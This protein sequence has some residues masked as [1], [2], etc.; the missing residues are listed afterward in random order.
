MMS[1]YAQANL[2]V[3]LEAATRGQESEARGS[4]RVS[5]R[6][7]DAAVVDAVAVR[8]GGWAG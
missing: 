1:R 6:Q 8:R 3:D 7:D 5:R 4:Q 2:P